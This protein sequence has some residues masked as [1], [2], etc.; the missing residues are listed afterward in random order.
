MLLRCLVERL[1]SPHPLSL[2]RCYIPCI[3]NEGQETQARDVLDLSSGRFRF[4]A[5]FP[6]WA[7]LIVGGREGQASCALRLKSRRGL[8]TWEQAPQGM[9]ES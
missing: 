6:E 4:W 3:L 2:L 1:C 5:K 9:P 8:S 7:L